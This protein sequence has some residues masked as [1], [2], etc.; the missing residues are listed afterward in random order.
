MRNEV[1]AVS[2]GD[3]LAPS[4]VARQAGRT[5]ATVRWWADKGLLP[6]KRTVGGRRMF[7]RADVDRFLAQRHAAKAEAGQ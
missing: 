4:D 1:E 2:P 3:V 5:P 6:V 7:L